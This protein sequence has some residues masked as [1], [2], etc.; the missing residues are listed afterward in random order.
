MRHEMEVHQR[1]RTMSKE[2]EKDNPSPVYM[3]TGGTKLEEMSTEGYEG[4]E[5]A[6]GGALRV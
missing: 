2:D 5:G 6:G 4:A 1:R 3:D